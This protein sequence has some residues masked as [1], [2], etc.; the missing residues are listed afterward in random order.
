MHIIIYQVNCKTDCANFPWRQQS[1]YFILHLELSFLNSLNLLH[2]IKGYKFYERASFIAMTAVKL[3][4]HSRH[5]AP[6]AFLNMQRLSRCPKTSVK[7]AYQLFCS[8]SIMATNAEDKQVTHA[9][10]INSTT[11]KITDKERT[12]MFM[13]NVL[14]KYGETHQ[15]NCNAPLSHTAILEDGSTSNLGKWLQTQRYKFRSGTLK[16]H[17]KMLLQELVDAGH[18]DWF[19]DKSK[20]NYNKESWMEYYNVLISYIQQN[21]NNIYLS[22]RERFTLPDGRKLSLGRWLRSQQQLFVQ[23]TL[24]SDRKALLQDL[25][26]DGRLSWQCIEGN[27][28]SVDDISWTHQYEALLEYGEEHGGDCNITMPEKVMLT[29]GRTVSLGRWLG[30]QRTLNKNDRLR[31]DRK[32][33]LQSLVD[34]GKLVWSFDIGEYNT[35]DDAWD[36]RYDALVDY[37]E[38]KE[39]NCNIPFLESRALDDGTEV[40]LG[41]W[42][43]KQRQMFKNNELRQDRQA[44]LQQLVDA[45]KLKWAI[46][47][48]WE[49]RYHSMLSFAKNHGGTCEIPRHYAG[50]FDHG[51]DTGMGRWLQYQKISHKEGRLMPERERKLQALVDQNMLSWDIL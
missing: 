43:D 13:L 44:R 28:G 35:D 1:A 27:P 32:A 17:R 5:L 6:V 9:T 11:N 33:L 19:K 49:D 8:F 50:Y 40:P 12:W 10:M 51:F 25:V 37:G 14:K 4:L 48:V 30:K 41:S 39:G 7:Y 36:A 42:L 47:V 38:E 29:G 46:N 18:L 2:Q 3:V 15:N 45:G 16:E 21:G 26:D 23:G 22:T 31:P 34:A 24:R 20:L